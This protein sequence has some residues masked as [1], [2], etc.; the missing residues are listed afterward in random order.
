M[1]NNQGTFDFDGADTLG[2]NGTINNTSTG[3]VLASAPATDSTNIGQVTFNDLG[4]TIGVQSGT[5]DL[6]QGVSQ[7]GTYIVASGADLELAN[8]FDR[9]ISGTFTGSGGGTVSIDTQSN[10]LYL[11]DSGATFDFPAGMLQLAGELTPVTAGANPV[12]LNSGFMTVPAHS[13]FT[14]TA[15]TL[16]N[17]GTLT[18]TGTSAGFYVDGA[19]VVDNTGTID[20]EGDVLL[21]GDGTLNN[22]GTL[23]AALSADDLAQVSYNLNNTGTIDV[24]SGALSLA[25]AAVTQEN[26]LNNGVSV[27]LTGGT[28]E[29]QGTGTLTTVRSTFIITQ[30]TGGTVILNGADASFPSLAGLAANGGSFALEGGAL[31][32]TRGDLSNSGALTVG[33]GSTLAVTGAFSQAGGGLTTF[34]IDG[35]SASGQYGRLTSSGAAVLDGTIAA[36]ADAGYTPVDG[37][38][39]TVMTFTSQT[40]DSTF[41]GGVTL[42]AKFNATN[43]VVTVVAQPVDLAVTG[44][45]LT[46]AT[47]APGGAVTVN[48]AVQNL[49]QAAT[50]RGLVDRLGLPVNPRRLRFVGGT[51]GPHHS[52]GE[53]GRRRQLR[54]YTDRAAAGFGARDVPRVRGD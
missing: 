21:G 38:P 52:R 11:A 19:A 34:A 35:T 25:E 45:T 31:F 17:A 30:I 47:A 9:T 15:G 51:A 4:G 43:V 12:F 41:S 26:V 6:G 13:E 8:G 42:G 27:E 7:G 50:R 10:S 53:P 48:Y 36:Q 16:E 24:Q 28:W 2:S 3:T 32:T 44:V 37:S 20:L 40:G 49:A 33:A 29:A 1:I 18:V 23:T 5:L 22:S 46:T 39:Y 54:R 14:W